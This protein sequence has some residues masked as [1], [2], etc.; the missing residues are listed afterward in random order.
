MRKYYCVHDDPLAFRGRTGLFD[1]ARRTS[2]VPPWPLLKKDRAFSFLFYWFPKAL[3]LPHL[4]QA[5]PD[6]GFGRLS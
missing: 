6:L 2:A 5:E 3:E 4:R 1:L